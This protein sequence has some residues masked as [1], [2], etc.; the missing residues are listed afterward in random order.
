MLHLV[1]VL[2]ACE[3]LGWDLAYLPATC[4]SLSARPAI[5]EEPGLYSISGSISYPFTNYSE[6]K[7]R[8]S[9]LPLSTQSTPCTLS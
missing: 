3:E 2:G 9:F 8:V 5:E 1:Q 7:N 4:L 6:V